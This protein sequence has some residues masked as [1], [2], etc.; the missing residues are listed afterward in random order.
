M[1]SVGVGDTLSRV[2]HLVL[3]SIGWQ[4]LQDFECLILENASANVG[5]VEKCMSFPKG[6]INT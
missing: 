3:W 2:F 6:C 5:I 1:Y 4:M